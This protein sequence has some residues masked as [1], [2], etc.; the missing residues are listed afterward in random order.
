MAVE[1]SQINDRKITNWSYITDSHPACY[2]MS[3]AACQKIIRSAMK[4]SNPLSR[5]ILILPD[6]RNPAGLG[7]PVQNT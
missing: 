4:S 2:R 1:L 3:S 5:Q 6:S 7:Q